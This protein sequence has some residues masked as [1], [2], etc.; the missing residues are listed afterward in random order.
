M[1]IDYSVLAL[2]KGKP[3]SVLKDERDH[4]RQSVDER[5]NDKVKARSGGQCEI[6]NPER[7]Q[8]RANQVHHMLGGRGVRG[9]G[10]SALAV[11]KQHACDKCHAAITSHRLQRIGSAVPHWTDSYR[12]AA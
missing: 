8:R 3:K 4:A 6:K 9:R 11:R 12:K 5:E 10:E 1:P 2:P 7:C